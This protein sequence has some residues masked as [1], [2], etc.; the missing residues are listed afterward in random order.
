MTA[1]GLPHQTIPARG[2]QVPFEGDCK[3][4]PWEYEVTAAIPTIDSAE[5]LHLVV[6]LLRLQTVRPFIVIVDTGSKPEQ[7]R[8]LE[9]M[10][11]EDVEVHQMRLNGVE[12]SSEPIAMAMD[13]IMARCPTRFLFC[14]H[15]D[16]FLRA[17]DALERFRDLAAVHAAA[18]HQ[19][20]KRPH[21]DW[22]RMVGHTALMLDNDRLLDLGVTWNMR[23]SMR[24]FGIE[25]ARREEQYGNWP[26]TEVGLNYMLWDN[27]IRPF[28]TGEEKN[29][30][31][32]CDDLI[33]HCRSTG[34]SALYSQ[35]YSKIA[36]NRL[37]DAVVDAKHRVNEWSRTR[38]AQAERLPPVPVTSKR[39]RPG[40]T[41]GNL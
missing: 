1:S 13:W 17:R 34:S 37:Q 36:Q 9:A 28:I 40:F 5:R 27:G 2:L 41:P 32:N 24:T 18:G 30:A 11:A 25:R 39:E 38:V 16:C 3:L 12:H 6:S 26:D 15:D 33:D 14:T 35:G 4:K 22:S 23:R 19:L 29:F 8:A 31:R 20:T 7:A 10:R 21:D